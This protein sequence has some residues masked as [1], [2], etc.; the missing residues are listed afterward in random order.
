MWTYS[1]VI[2]AGM[3]SPGTDKR[4]T[5]NWWQKGVEVELMT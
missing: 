1:Q 3:N 2:D 4:L 5:T